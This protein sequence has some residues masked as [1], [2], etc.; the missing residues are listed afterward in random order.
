MENKKLFAILVGIVVVALLA[1]G[2]VFFKKNQGNKVLKNNKLENHQ[3]IPPKPKP[4]KLSEEKKVKT[5]AEN[6]ARSYYSYTWGE[7]GIIEGLYYDMTDKMKE[8]EMARVER[9]KEKIKS[10]PR[11]YF[12]VKAEVINSEFIEFTENTRASLNVDLEIKEINGAFVTDTDVPEIKPQTTALVDG[13][14]NV[15][16][17]DMRDLVVNTANKN[18]KI[19]LVK[20]GDKWKVNG[21]GS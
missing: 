20:I 10:Q 14:G 21:I 7:F 11:R 16:D 6:F 3:V 12:T 1:A 19:N 18:V 15:Y 17:G 2:M 9:I 4:R 5:M 13:D 8:R